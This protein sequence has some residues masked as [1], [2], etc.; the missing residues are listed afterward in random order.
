MK[1]LIHFAPYWILVLAG[2][3]LIGYRH[4]QDWAWPNEHR[5]EHYRARHHLGRNPYQRTVAGCLRRSVHPLTMRQALI[6]VAA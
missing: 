3:V 1:H 5:P 4:Y 2:L 6:A